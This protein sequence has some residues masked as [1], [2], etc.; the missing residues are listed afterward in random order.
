MSAT[1]DWGEALRREATFVYGAAG[2]ELA[3]T[4]IGRA[5]RFRSA[6]PRPAVPPE[7]RMS[8]RDA[9]LISYADSIRREGEAPLRT[10]RRWL[11]GPLAGTVST[12]HVLPFYP[13]SS[14]DGFAVRDY[15]AV[16]P[17]YG[18]WEDV[19][20]LAEGHRLMVD[21]VVNHAS[22][23]G[24]W[25]A[26]FLRDEAP[27]R[28]W[29]RTEAEDADVRS[30]VRP[31]TTPLLTPFDTAAGRRWAWT[32][33]GPDQVDLDYRRP[34]LLLEIV[35]VLLDY[36]AHGAEVLRMDAVTY[37]WKELGTPSVHHP[38]THA[39]LR[40]MRA[41]L[42]LA[43]P[44]VVLLTETNVPHDENVAYFGAGDD[45][46]QMV[47]N[48]ALPPLLLHTI[49]S[50]DASILREWAGTLRTPS[51]STWFLNFLASHDG[52]GV[53]PVEALLPR[54]AVDALVART[55]AQGGG[56]GRKRDADGGESPYELNVNYFDALRTPGVEEPLAR[57]VARF[58]AAYA[59]AMALPG[60]PAL[61]VHS[62]LGSVGS[63]ELVAERGIPRAINRAKLDEDRLRRELADAGGR[64][65]RVLAAL[66]R[67]ATVR[68][69]Q[70]AFHPAAPTEVLDAPR[71]VFALRR[72]DDAPI[73]AV[74]ELAGEAAEVRLPTA[75][76]DL[77]G[78]RTLEAGPVRL[79]P[80]QVLWVRARPTPRP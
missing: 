80:Y 50:R 77:L 14:D 15:R 32:T 62:L 3:D 26:G 6:H 8:E 23:Q 64:R 71:G 19:N 65:A 73:L 38:K 79:E 13:W 75:G 12:V 55:L 69:S 56:V 44:W 22:A 30:I 54:A 52:V 20:A 59:V 39:L 2:D 17:E 21:A 29:F 27:E 33:F 47:Y 31:R 16:A 11:E 46:A 61:Y 28:D 10:L 25:F 58:A 41:V 68:R 37:L 34:G 76:V 45:E 70:A 48:F 4:L 18:A 57:Q 43:A 53:R 5:R 67:L 9:L 72:G 63:P 1:R 74:H 7:D 36:V 60:V 35:D 40:L 78:G 24:T 42:E 66:R 49:A 51:A